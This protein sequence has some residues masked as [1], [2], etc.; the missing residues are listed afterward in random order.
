M[1][2]TG[3][4]SEVDL[5]G[6][7]REAKMTYGATDYILLVTVLYKNEPTQLSTEQRGLTLDQ[8]AE[9]YE[10]ACEAARRAVIK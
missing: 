6:K 2:R 3:A 5:H 7:Q 10:A 9:A 1:V 8:A 4:L